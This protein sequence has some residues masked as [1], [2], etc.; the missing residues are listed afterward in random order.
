MKLLEV[1]GGKAGPR[2]YF[3]K[4]N[5]HNLIVARRFQKGPFLQKKLVFFM[6]K[7]MKLMLKK[8]TLQ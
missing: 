3:C 4:M 1:D 6:H 8:K 7:R 2:P 5:P